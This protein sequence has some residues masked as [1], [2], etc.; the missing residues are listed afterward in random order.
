MLQNIWIAEADESA[1]TMLLP[2]IKNHPTA[3]SSGATL[4]MLRLGG[5]QSVEFS[6]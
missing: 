1:E 3:Y 2:N 6:C 4:M 5:G